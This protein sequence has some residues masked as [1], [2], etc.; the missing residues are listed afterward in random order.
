MVSTL[1]RALPIVGAAL[2]RKLGVQVEVSG[3]NAFTDGERIV[4]PAFDPERPEQELK[5]WGFLSHEAAHIRYTDFELDQSG[6][7]FRRR[8][9]NLLEDIRIERA[10]SR[11][12]PGTAFTL[13]E[14]VRQLVAEGRLSAPAKSDPP[15]K[16]L[17]DSLLAMLRYEVLGQKA[18]KEEA[19][20]AKQAMAACFP[21]KLLKSLDAVLDDVPH[22]GNTRKAQQLAD[23][24]IR[25]FQNQQQEDSDNS[26]D[27]GNDDKTDS[28]SS[29]NSD[30]QEPDLKSAPS[31]GTDE[32]PDSTLATEHETENTQG[33]EKQEEKTDSTQSTDAKSADTQGKRDASGENTT[34]APEDFQE[35][36][37]RTVLESDNSDWPEDLFQSLASEME[38]WS[39]RQEGGLSAVTTTPSVDRV[40][41]LNADKIEGQSLLWR[42]KAE[43]SRLAAQLTGL[44][45]AKT[46]SRDRTGKRGKKLDGKLLH[47]MA[48][49]DSRLFCKRSETITIDA[50]VHLCLDISSSMSSR[51]ELAREAVLALA[52]GLNQINGV[53]VSV[54]AYP[55]KNDSG[56]FEVMK[57]NDQLQDMAAVLSALNA[58]DSTPMATGL[59]HSVHQVLQA[60]AKRRLIIMIT[61]GAPDF[62][63]HQPVMDL[64]KRCESSAIEV[65]GLGINVHS[66]EQLFPRSVVITELHELKSALFEQARLL[67]VA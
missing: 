29:E 16:V 3:R 46:M 30:N 8:L 28:L 58:H 15:V 36:S 22:M 11:E 17:H 40:E 39:L 14:V 62:D 54:S 1:Q 66:V 45:Q 35:E 41:V 60:R 6:S 51:M 2:G 56:V 52:Y 25:L 19:S 31:Q 63:H 43:S 32:K 49:G 27:T 53:T 38:G 33:Q 48:I 37:I 65:V 67:L 24:I 55:G 10:L 50:T 59:W 26:N 20:K 13:S 12:Y 34:E 64:V 9:T 23:E 7:A 47:R 42:T 44:V 18:L 4:L 61:D 5:S 21:V 57:P